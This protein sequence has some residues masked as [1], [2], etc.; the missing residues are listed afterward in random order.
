VERGVA[1]VGVVAAL[2]GL[3]AGA[4]AITDARHQRAEIAHMVET[5]ATAQRDEERALKRAALQ[6]ELCE[7]ERQ[8]QLQKLQ[9]CGGESDGG[10]CVCV[11]GDPLC[12]C[13]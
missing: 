9:L 8:K 12:T 2:L 13:L 5:L 4:I 10:K 1:I 7:V 6:L 11:P 3:G